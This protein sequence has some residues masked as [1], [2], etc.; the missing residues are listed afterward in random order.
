LP[1]AKH[2]GGAKG[3]KTAAKK[4]AVKKTT[5][6]RYMRKKSAR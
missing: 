2:P 6:K 4:T 5:G 1:L 3:K